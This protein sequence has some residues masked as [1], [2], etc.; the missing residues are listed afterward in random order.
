MQYFKILLILLVTKF[1]HAGVLGNSIFIEPYAGYRSENIKLTD[2]VSAST[3]I[4][5]SQPNF[6]LKLGYR[7]MLGIDLNLA[8]EYFSGSA[9]VSGQT[10][11]SKFSHKSASVQLG[12]NALGLVKMYL[13]TAFINEFTL[14]DTSSLT[15]FKLSGPSFHAGLQFKMFPFLNLGLQYNLNQYKT[16]EGTAYATGDKVETYYSKTD[17]SDYS[18]YLSTSF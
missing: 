15:G 12:V 10:D 13:G 4:K 6:G 1:A 3:E 5:A 8:G 9:S 14:E 16:I 11:N 7:S 17:S 18:L 2:L